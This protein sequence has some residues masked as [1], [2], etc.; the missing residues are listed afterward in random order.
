MTES[1]ELVA[2]RKRLG[3]PIEGLPAETQKQIAVAAIEQVLDGIEQQIVALDD[4][5][6][7]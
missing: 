7:R 3:G 1:P 6:K 5:E 4:W 2:L